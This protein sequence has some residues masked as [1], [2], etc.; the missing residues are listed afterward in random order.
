[1]GIPETMMAKKRF[2]HGFLTLLVLIIFGVAGCGYK[3][4]PIPP[5]EIVPKAITDLRYELDEKGVTL[6]WT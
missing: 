3:T 4:M 2:V 5:G 6:N 1:M